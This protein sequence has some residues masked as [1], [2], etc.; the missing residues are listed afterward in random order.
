MRKLKATLLGAFLF[1][2]LLAPLFTA[3][4]PNVAP[5]GTPVIKGYKN[6]VTYCFKS[7]GSDLY[8]IYGT[9]PKPEYPGALESYDIYVRDEVNGTVTIYY[10]FG[11]GGYYNCYKESADGSPIKIRPAVYTDFVYEYE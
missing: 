4:D 11:G 8:T 10:S 6:G 9:N 2:L 5:T 1:A 3:C 7:K